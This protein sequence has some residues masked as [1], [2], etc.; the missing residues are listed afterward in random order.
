MKVIKPKSNQRTNLK[1]DKDG[2]RINQSIRVLS[3]R[4]IDENGAQAGI[5]PTSEALIKAA[6]LGLDL[7]EV[8]ADAKPPVCKIMN[9]SK[10]KFEKH[11]KEKANKVTQP[12]IKE[13][14]FRGSI[15]D[16]D[17]A[18]RIESAKEFLSKGHK[19]KF[20]LRFKGREITHVEYGIK[21]L[22]KAKLDLV[23]HGNIDAES[24]LENK[25][26]HIIWSPK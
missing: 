11:K 23:E 19:V 16:N 1:P 12:K 3:I 7:V 15:S 17:Y 24:R 14:K 13:I 21:V 26:M 25:S 6:S 20:T 4:L 5:V 8:S 22:D 18:Y 2:T 9:Y 10:F